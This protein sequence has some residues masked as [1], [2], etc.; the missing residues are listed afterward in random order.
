MPRPTAE[1][2]PEEQRLLD[3]F[4]SKKVASERSKKKYAGLLRMFKAITGRSL[5][6]AS[7]DDVRLWY[8][9][10]R[11]RYRASTL[12]NHAF[13]LRALY[14]FVL[15]WRH[16][17]SEEEAELRAKRIF[18]C[19][20][21][22]R[23]AQLEREECEL[24]DKV[25]SSDEVEAL[26]R[27]ADHP[28]LKAMI[29]VHAETGLR[30]GELLSLRLRDVR[31]SERYA[32]LWV[33]GKTGERAVPIIRSLPYLQAWLAAHPAKD[34]PDAP[35]FAVVRRGQ[36]KFMTYEAYEKALRRLAERVGLGRRI[37][38]Y[39]FRHTRLTE[40]AARG[41][42]EYQMKQFAG[43]T[44]S[45]R[46]AERYIRLGRHAGL[47]AVLA[48]EGIA[49]AERPRQEPTLRTLVCPRCGH[50]NMADAIYCARCGLCLSEEEAIRAVAIRNHLDELLA[51]LLEHP[52]VRVA[53][54]KALKELISQGFEQGRGAGAGIRTRVSGSAAR[55]LS[56]SATP[57]LTDRAPWEQYKLFSSRGLLELL[58]E[59]H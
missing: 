28:R 25:L 37:Y 57:A 18:S 56:L 54:K 47:Q 48:L 33:S 58:N 6:G 8:E 40:L 24:R 19:I 4:C 31:F 3:A 59:A 23:L 55:R 45:S 44:T 35:L 13:K 42:G 11:D 38:P 14:A 2:S 50:E 39:M 16:G 5:L 27:A 7:A 21:F 30:T 51:Q 29:A 43:W 32:V 22:A 46:M 26:L 15:A 49:E 12:L 52:E 20:P 34:D 17:L 53:L 10:V 41:M 36:V 9:R 1:L